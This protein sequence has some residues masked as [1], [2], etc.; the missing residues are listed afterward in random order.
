MTGTPEEGKVEYFI[1]EGK[2]LKLK[3]KDIFVYQRGQTI[4]EKEEFRNITD[5]ESKVPRQ[6][7]LLQKN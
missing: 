2:I 4:P 5:K 6:K 1:I 3:I 7:Q